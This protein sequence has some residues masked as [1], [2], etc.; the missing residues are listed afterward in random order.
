MGRWRHGGPICE[1]CPAI[2]V[3][4]WQREGRLLPGQSF[5]VAWACDGQQCTS[6]GVRTEWQSVVLNVS[7]PTGRG[8]G[9]HPAAGADHLDAVSPGWLPAVVSLQRPNQWPA[10]RTPGRAALR[11]KRSFCVPKL[12]RLDLRKPTTNFS[13][14]AGL[15]KA[16]EDSSS[17]ERRREHVRRFPGKAEGHAPA[18]LHTSAPFSQI[19]LH[20]AAGADAAIQPFQ[21]GGSAAEGDAKEG[22]DALRHCHPHA[23]N[24]THHFLLFW[25]NRK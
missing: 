7:G 17:V 12:L 2:D 16:R 21:R 18:K 14:T 20:Y 4:R 10:L 5:E 6:I 8:V 24:L 13:G 22:Q 3:R 9:S 25:E 15:A 23:G 11:G 1:T 19:S